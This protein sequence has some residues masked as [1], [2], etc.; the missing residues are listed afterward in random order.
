MFAS[1]IENGAARADFE[2]FGW[3]SALNA[4]AILQFWEEMDPGIYDGIE[5]SLPGT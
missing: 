4:R 2:R 1:G 5:D 3:M